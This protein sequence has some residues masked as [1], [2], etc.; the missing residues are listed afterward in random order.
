MKKP[1]VIL[2]L[3]AFAFAT[4]MSAAELTHRWSFNEDY[5]DSIGSADAARCGKEDAHPYVSLYGGMVHMG[6]GGCDHGSGYVN[7]GANLLDTD[8]ATIELWA[9]HD[10]AKNWSRIFDYGSDDAHY[11][12]M[13]W[14]FGTT[15]SNDRVAG[16][17]GSEVFAD[18]SMAPYELG[19]EYYIAATFRRQGDATIVNWQRRNAETG[20]LQKSGTLTMPDGMHNFTDPVLY[21]GHSQFTGDKDALAAYDEVRIWRGVL[22]DSELAA[23]AAAG[24]NAAIATNDGAIVFTPAETVPPSIPEPRPEGLVKLMTFNIQYCYDQTKDADGKTNNTIVP[25]RTAARIIAEAP[26]FCG[27]N[28]VRDSEGHPEARLLA[29][30]TGMHYTFDGYNTLLSRTEPLSW[31]SIALPYNHYARGILICEFPGCYVAVTHLDYAAS[32]EDVRIE[33]AAIIKEEVATCTKPVFIVGDWNTKPTYESFAK[34]CEFA[35]ILSPTDTAGTY[36]G[37]NGTPQYT[38]DYI[39]VDTAHKDSILLHS[40]QVVPDYTTSDH[41]PVTVEFWT[42]AQSVEEWVNESALTAG[43]TGS[44]NKPVSY[45]GETLKAEMNGEYTFTA[46]DTPAADSRVT[47]EMTASF[48]IP[49]AS[50]PLAVSPQGAMRLGTEGVFQ[51]WT[52]DAWRDV[53]AETITPANDAEY[54]IRFVLDCRKRKYTVEIMDANGRY[55]TLKDS[56]GNA[57]FAMKAQGDAIKKVTLQGETEFTSLAGE[58]VSAS[59]F[60]ENESVALSGASKVLSA[61]RAAWLNGLGGKP[62]VEAALSTLTESK[63]DEAFL[64][65]FNFT[66]GDFSYTFD[67]TDINVFNDHVEVSV[68][69][70]RNG[71][72]GGTVNGILKFYGAATLESFK[73]GGELVGTAGFAAGASGSEE[74][75]TVAI[76]LDGESKPAFFKARIEE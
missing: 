9:R 18:G 62:D 64:L 27:I 12:T 33:S 66:Q 28:E 34:M 45:S 59:G 26:D 57:E 40:A 39:A 54:R 17:T 56:A 37:A 50:S 38:I 35:T 63:F 1:L 75:A 31:K 73:K 69:L 7:L 51:V 55:Q 60:E 11:F 29:K 10:G 48:C 3:A 30:L 44:W 22:S 13:A 74:T 15:L 16:K 47:M 8:A 21:L 61:A 43:L 58:W 20:E 46:T 68:S 4:G 23:S 25:D 24:C 70:S 76:P 65:N 36:L 5:A 32:D 71:A 52:D 53:F 14:S 19:T 2:S 42:K 72:A 41:A 49:T 67:I 6:Y